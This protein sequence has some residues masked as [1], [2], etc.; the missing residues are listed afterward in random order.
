[1]KKRTNNFP[2][3]SSRKSA[4]HLVQTLASQGF[5]E[6]EIA[7]RHGI[8]KNELRAR[9]IDAIK[10]GRRLAENDD[11]MSRSELLAADTFL[12]AFNSHWQ[13]PEGNDLWDGLSGNGA[14]SAADAYA[15]WKLD[16]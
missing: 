13:T 5:V 14:V 12:S 15:K 9:Y 3:K 1:M 10:R 2:K 6:D 7:Q 11:D 4:A 8:D 16:G